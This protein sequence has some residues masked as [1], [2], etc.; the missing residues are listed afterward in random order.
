MKLAWSVSLLVIAGITIVS[1]ICNFCGVDLSDNLIR[2]FG[3]LD[4]CAVVVLVYTSV[5]LRN[6]KK[7]K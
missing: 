2:I 7:K 4:L 3:I 1:T 6:E 5:K